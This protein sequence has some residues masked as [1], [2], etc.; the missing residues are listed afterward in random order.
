MQTMSP[1]EM[2]LITELLSLLT[3]EERNAVTAN[4]EKTQSSADIIRLLEEYLGENTLCPNCEGHHI[5]PWGIRSGLHRHR[6]RDCGRTF[7]VLAGTP[8]A[9]L[10]YKEKWLPY[11]RTMASS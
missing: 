5:A 9:R 8:L 10:R 3:P 6:C 7:N 2:N 4:I 11:L 1:D